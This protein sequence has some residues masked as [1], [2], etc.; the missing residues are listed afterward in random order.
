MIA[1]RRPFTAGL[2]ALALAVGT[3]AC[4]ETA[5][6]SKFTGESHNVAQTVSDFQSDA[7]AGNGKK[8]CQN[9][10]AGTLTAHLQGAGGCQAVLKN[11]LHEVDAL[12]M[13]IESITVSGGA[14]VAH[15]KSTWS[16]KN[17]ITTLTLAKEGSRWKISGAQS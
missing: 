7:T 8:L 4:G 1:S 11:Q 13:T 17:R 14:A 12:N 9:D 3:T 10:L 6:T 5:S 16:G 15:V 2:F